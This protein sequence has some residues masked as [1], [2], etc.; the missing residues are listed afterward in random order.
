M[1]GPRANEGGG[2]RSTYKITSIGKAG[3][4]D[5]R[6][7]NH[8]EERPQHH[9]WNLVSLGKSARLEEPQLLHIC[10]LW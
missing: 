9:A 7:L 10:L 4:G 3:V 5:H 8:V 1:S 2:M 6:E